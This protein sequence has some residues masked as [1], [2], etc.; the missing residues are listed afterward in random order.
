MAR[1]TVIRYTYRCPRCRTDI[2]RRFGLITS[3]R[4]V[5]PCCGTYVRIDAQVIQQN[6]G[7]NFGWAAGLLT[8][9][10]LATAM[11]AS[12]EFAA[13]FG[14]NTFPSATLENR[15]ALAA[16]CCIPSLF[17]GGAV[18][19][20]GMLLGALVAA[21]AEDSDTARGYPPP[22]SPT[23][24]LAPRPA[25]FHPRTDPTAPPP[26]PRQRGFLVRAC[27]VLLWPVVFFFGAA[28]VVQQVAVNA[29]NHDEPLPLI[30]ASTVG[31]MGCPQGQGPL[32]AASS[33]VP[34]EARD[35]QRKQFATAKLADK[36]VP[37]ILL[38][39]LV[40]FV[41]GCVGVLPSTGRKI[42]AQVLAPP[43][44]A[45][46]PE[47]QQRGCLVRTFFVLLWPI[48]FFIVVG[49]TMSA[50]AGSFSA[51]SEEVRKQ[52]SEQSARQHAGWISLVSLLLFIL[53]CLGLLPIT[54]AKKRSRAA[55][56]GSPG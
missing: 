20:V 21:G 36:P 43:A 29:L 35:E 40:A 52:I 34:G 17:V 39:S 44:P 2:G 22:P 56:D 46:G 13:A 55:A 11:L 16:M 8:W 25:G 4:I 1:V 14:G 53:G 38:G 18:A 50:L 6:W 32:L 10:G 45:S 23:W 12:P 7:F 31:L 19:A 27:F 3:A 49:L 42:R 28:T 33:L 9:L 26:R 51:E 47:A 48:A 30:G 37:W 24:G 41:L 15:L 54:G 5:C